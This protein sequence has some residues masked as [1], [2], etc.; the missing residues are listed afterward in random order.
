MQ[1]TEVQSTHCRAHFCPQDATFN[2]LSG[3]ICIVDANTILYFLNQTVVKSS[4]F[5]ASP[6]LYLI[7]GT[8]AETA[9]IY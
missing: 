3:V 4:S 9:E 5:D 8:R 1:R 2:M 6:K 7:L